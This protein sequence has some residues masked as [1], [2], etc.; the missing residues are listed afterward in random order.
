MTSV[1]ASES[2]IATL[3]ERMN[4][5]PAFALR[6]A[7]TLQLPEY[8]VEWQA[9]DSIA[10]R[11]GA[12]R[13][14][15]DVLLDYLVSIEAIEQDQQGRVRLAPMGAV[16]LRDHPTGL[17]QNWDMSSVAY[18]MERA[19]AGLLD[20]VRTGRPAYPTEYGRELYKD[21]DENERFVDEALS[22]AG[23]IVDYSASRLAKWLSLP[24]SSTVADLGCGTGIHLVRILGENPSCRGIAVDLPGTLS[25][26]SA[27]MG[28]SEAWHRIE[29]IPSDLFASPVPMADTYLL[30]NVLID[31]DDEKARQLLRRVRESSTD[32]SRLVVLELD[33]DMTDPTLAAHLRLHQLCMSGGRMRNKSEISDLAVAEGFTLDRAEHFGGGITVFAF[34]PTQPQ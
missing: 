31:L 30:S 15:I 34:A 12:D 24:E 1:E 28:K 11:V 26:A 22:S 25:R 21:I 3:V 2:A 33:R 32:G 18:R 27:E 17:A 23:P 8:L 10:A 14:A 20:V 5:V 4:T 19:F 29:L 9:K 7:V 6:T 13:E 16:L